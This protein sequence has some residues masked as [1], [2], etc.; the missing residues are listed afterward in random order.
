MSEFEMWV[1]RGLI[2]L[3]IAV[4]GWVIKNFTTKVTRKL[5]ELIDAMN[6][7]SGK[8]IAQEGQIK[9]VVDVQSDHAKRLN[10]H[11]ERLRQVEIKQAKF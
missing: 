6:S 4:I 3:L 10:D 7:L 5:D 2:G 11:S 8:Y 9:Q 1:Y